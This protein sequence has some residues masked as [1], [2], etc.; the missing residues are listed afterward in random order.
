MADEIADEVDFFSIGTNDLIQYTLA[1]DRVNEKVASLYSPTHPAILQ[2][3]SRV[4]KA[5]DR[6]K[7]DVSLC[8]EMASD[9]E[10]TPLLL[11]LGFRTLSLSPPM[12]PEVKKVIRLVSM[13]QCRQMARKALTFDTD[14]QTINFLREE[15]RKISSNGKN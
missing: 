12:I 2:L 11:G 5:A 6:A 13:E 4:V 15:F 14:T 10:Y 1:V 3:L 7:I 8:G 9:P